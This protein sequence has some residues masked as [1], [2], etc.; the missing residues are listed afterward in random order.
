MREKETKMNSVQLMGRLTRDPELRYTQSGT[1]TCS[2]N[3]AVDRG[4][5]KEK[6]KEAEAKGYPTADFIRCTTWGKTAELAGQYLSKG[7]RILIEGRIQTGSYTNKEGQK[8]YTTDVVI[9]NLH[10]IDWGE[11]GTGQGQGYGNQGQDDGDFIPFNDDSQI[12]F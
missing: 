3:L 1:A 4:L 6:K 7:L 8:V 12:P 9:R 5:S 10:F 2:F 11:G